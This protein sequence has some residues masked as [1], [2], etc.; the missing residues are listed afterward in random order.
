V[1]LSAPLSAKPAEVRVAY[2]DRNYETRAGWKEVVACAGPGI[3]LRDSTVPAKDQSAELTKYPKF[4][5]PLAV[6]EAR[7]AFA[8]EMNASESP[9]RRN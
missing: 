4:T 6:T 1:D 2:R 5:A 7:F 8:P 9:A 3:A